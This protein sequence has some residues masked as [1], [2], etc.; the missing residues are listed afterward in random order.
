MVEGCLEGC[1]ATGRTCSRGS[2]EVGEETSFEVSREKVLR[3]C[4]SDDICFT[5]EEW[6]VTRIVSRHWDTA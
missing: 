6:T 3:Q 4:R 2:E 5:L 1:P